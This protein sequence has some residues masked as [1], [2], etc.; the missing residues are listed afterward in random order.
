MDSSALATPSIRPLTVTSAISWSQ[1]AVWCTFA[2]KTL[3]EHRRK[4]GGTLWLVPSYP[5]PKPMI[6]KKP[7]EEALG[8]DA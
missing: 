7:P 1:W 8:G 4:K 3:A 6:S 5:E 2:Q